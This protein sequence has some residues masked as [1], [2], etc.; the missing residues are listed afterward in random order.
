MN[1]L[2]SGQRNRPLC[3]DITSQVCIF[4]S[5]T[6]FLPIYPFTNLIQQMYSFCCHKFN[7]SSFSEAIF[8]GSTTFLSE[9]WKELQHQTVFRLRKQRHEMYVKTVEV[10]ATIN[11]LLPYDPTNDLPSSGLGRYVCW[12]CRGLGH[13]G[14]AVLK[15]RWTGHSVVI[16]SSPILSPIQYSKGHT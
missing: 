4:V 16:W 7:C 3:K 14:L 10:Q 15:Q 9:F 11:F 5:L 1:R 2:T 6:I 12:G 8:S 13:L